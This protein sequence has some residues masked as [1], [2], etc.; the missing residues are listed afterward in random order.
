MNIV[1]P[2]CGKEYKLPDSFAGKKVK[3]K[4]CGVVLEIEVEDEPEEEVE[5]EPEPEEERTEQP[6]ESEEDF[7]DDANEEGYDDEEAE[8]ETEKPS[9]G[10][11]GKIVLI[12][13]C[14][15]F[16]GA[17]GAMG[18]LWFMGQQKIKD[19]EATHQQEVQKLKGDVDKV[20]ADLKAEKEK[21]QSLVKEYY[22][23]KEQKILFYDGFDTGM[24]EDRWKFEKGK[25]TTKNKRLVLKSDKGV[26]AFSKTRFS[27]DV[28]ISFAAKISPLKKDG[29]FSDIS[30]FLAADTAE[31]IKYG[32]FFGFGSNGNTKTKVMKRGEQIFIKPGKIINP[33]KPYYFRIVVKDESVKQYYKEGKSGEEKLIINLP[34]ARMPKKVNFGIYTYGSELMVDDVKIVK[35]E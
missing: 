20:T 18:Y 33:A 4:G 29:T 24:I 13:L 27:G 10:K 14:I 32:Y 34:N 35:I 9:G 7:G 6:A 5:E 19:A 3:C 11:G 15:L 1:C 26:H 2:E 21:Y 31:P 16:L 28:E 25:V 22:A 23:L 30:F 8:E 12:I 17:A